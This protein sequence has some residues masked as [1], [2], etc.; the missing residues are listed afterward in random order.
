M[1]AGRGAAV[2]ADADVSVAATATLAKNAERFID[3]CNRFVDVRSGV[4]GREE[5][6]FVLR[7]REQD[8]SFAHLVIVPRVLPFVRG[9]RVVVIAVRSA[10]AELEIDDRFVLHDRVRRAVTREYAA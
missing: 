4:R 9:E 3:G 8:F 2:A 1:L 5:Q 10:R 7:G 6:N